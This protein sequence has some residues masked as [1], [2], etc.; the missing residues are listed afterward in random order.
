MLRPALLTMLSNE[1]IFEGVHTHYHFALCSEEADLLYPTKPDSP[2][3]A[4]E[5]EA[6]GLPAK[7][8]AFLAAVAELG[9]ITRIEEQVRGIT[10]CYAG[11]TASFREHRVG[12]SGWSFESK[13][14]PCLNKHSGFGKWIRRVW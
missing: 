1:N 6:E 7:Q 9:T 2:T 13:H 14:D 8:V 12:I 3:R 11:S 10:F 5:I 4:K